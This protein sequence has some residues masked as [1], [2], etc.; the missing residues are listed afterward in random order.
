M[1]MAAV[2]LSVSGYHHQCISDTLEQSST[3]EIHQDTQNYKA[4]LRIAEMIMD[5]LPEKGF[6]IA[7][8]VFY[9]AIKERNV[10]DKAEAYK[11]MGNFYAR[12]HL[13]LR[14]M[15]KYE[16]AI[17][18]FALIHDTLSMI[19][20]KEKNG[21]ISA[22]LKH[23]ENAR[24]YFNIC[25]HW[26]I[27][28]HD[29]ANQGRQ[30]L[31]LGQIEQA[32][33]RFDHSDSCYAK[34]STLFKRTG[35]RK[36]WLQALIERGNRFLLQN[37]LAEAMQYYLNILK[38]ADSCHIHTFKG[39]VFTKMSHIY[40]LTQDKNQAVYYGLKAL[41]ARKQYS[42]LTEVAS[43]LVNLAGD[44]LLIGRVDT[45]MIL[46]E[47]GLYLA[48]KYNLHT[49]QIN[50]YR[51]LYNYYE[52]KKDNRNALF[53][54]ELYNSL[55]EMLDIDR[56]KT[57]Y[58]INMREL[59][60][61]EMDRAGSALLK[62]NEIKLL[63]LQNQQYPLLITSLLTAAILI[64]LVVLTIIFFYNRSARKKIQIAY[65]ELMV[66]NRERE[67][68]SQQIK[69]EEQKFRFLS[70]HSID[71]IVHYNSQQEIIYASPTAMHFFGYTPED[72]KGMTPVDLTHPDF[73][74][75]IRRQFLEMVE[76]KCERNLLYQAQRKDGNSFWVESVANPVFDRETNELKGIV[77]VV[78]NI[79]EKQSRE[80][81]IYE[82]MKQKENLLK[83][84]HHRV[85]NNFA[86]LV[87]LI[88]MQMSQYKDPTL[89]TA[90]TNL[91]LRVRSMSLVHEMLYR[92]EDF[93]RISVPEYIRSLSSVVAS[94][95]S[96]RKIRM[97]IEIDAG[98]MNIDTAIPIGLILTELI[99]NS[100]THAYSGS[101]EGTVEVR[102]VRLV[103][104]GHYCLTIRDDGCGLPAGFNIEAVQTM[105]L[106]IVQ[107]L[108]KQLD[109]G[110][111]IE[112]GKGTTFK[113][114]FLLQPG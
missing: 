60:L 82:G 27:L 104:E 39:L 109:A 20:V 62:E 111:A 64:I 95:L 9:N 102:F 83:E 85:K 68:K 8:R 112:T 45:A 94:T 81:E 47:E 29:L 26:S 100:Y 3:N 17:N 101:D 71:F 96:R 36:H 90:L 34:A 74:A 33:G 88:N 49:V 37:Q 25:L 48:R 12:N 57:D 46:I 113:I 70:E 42:P 106:Q 15:L 13:Y 63:M 24:E 76:M 19:A 50:G 86:I 73:H 87:S 77:A 114:D 103:Q 40:S 93:E 65:N 28:R 4:Q 16:A 53:Y 52:S 44:F 14:A 79:H 91:Q 69:E 59:E 99:T 80:L 30:Y 56:L 108:C 10:R 107:L 89:H 105:G 67:A 54:Y 31:H 23:F 35:D 58:K 2:P 32:A 92:S 11:L 7:C 43:S 97:V 1:M 72:L 84:I 38:I 6:E 18:N 98:H 78:R 51:H 66:E 5:T 75:Y 41:E 110:L 22:T 61:L 21:F 55:L